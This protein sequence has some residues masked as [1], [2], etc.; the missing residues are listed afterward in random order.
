MLRICLWILFMSILTVTSA[1]N[2]KLELS[3]GAATTNLEYETSQGNVHNH[4]LLLHS[5]LTYFIKPKIGIG[6]HANFPIEADNEVLIDTGETEITSFF[7]T[8]LSIHFTSN[9]EQVLQFRTPMGVFYQSESYIIYD[10]ETD[11]P[12]ETRM[13]PSGIGYSLNLG[14][15]IK[16]SRAITFN[17]I[18]AEA[19]WLNEGYDEG[20]PGAYGLM[21]SS[22]F[23]FMMVREK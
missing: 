18:D 5:G 6:I 9:R 15:G 20:S 2:R 16:L 21:L 10:F 19:Q 11:P 22:G 3:L 13:A 1:Q 7:K 12:T 23:I 8:G 17:L 14:V 4:H